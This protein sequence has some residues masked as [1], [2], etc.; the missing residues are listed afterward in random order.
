[1]TDEEKKLIQ[2]RKQLLGEMVAN[3]EVRLRE[4]DTV[5]P[6]DLV[7]IWLAISNNYTHNLVS[8]AGVRALQVLSVEVL[9]NQIEVNKMNMGN[10]VVTR[11]LKLEP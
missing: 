9:D 4:L 10:G 11:H 2:D 3:A 7:C 1:M 6:Y 5:S 8:S